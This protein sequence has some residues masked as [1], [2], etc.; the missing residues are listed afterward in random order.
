MDIKYAKEILRNLADGINPITGEILPKEDSC[1][2]VEIV[3]A[4]HAVLEEMEKTAEEEMTQPE[5]AGAPWSFEMDQELSKMAD[6]GCT[7]KQMC[8]YF[9]RSKGAIE[10]RL[11][12]LEERRERNES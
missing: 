4:L 7:R 8:T 1:N 9:K 11:K 2:Q 12:R 6:D 10:A 3:R 5:N